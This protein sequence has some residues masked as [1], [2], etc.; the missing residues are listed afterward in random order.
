MRMNKLSKSVLSVVLSGAMIMGMGV[1]AS[2]SEEQSAD[3]V[4]LGFQMYNLRVGGDWGNMQSQE[5][6]NDAL[7]QLAE[8][9][10]EGVEWFNT[11]LNDEFVDLEE[12]RATM[13]ELGLESI[14]MHYHYNSEDLE[15]SAQEVVERCQTLGCENL[16]FAYSVPSTFGIEPDED[17][18]YT[19]EQVDQWVSEIDRVIDALE[20]A[21]EGRDIR[22]LY[23]N[24]ATEMLTG[25]EGEH[26]LDMID[27]EGLEVDVYWTSKGLDG[28]VETA[29]DYVRE[30]AD[31]IYFL[32]MKDG[33]DGSLATGEMCGWG[34]GT[35][36]LQEIVDV[37]KEC[38][39]LEWVVVEN[40]NPNNFGLTGLEDAAESAEYAKANIDFSYAE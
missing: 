27:T 26:A 35:Y 13:D 15:G 28:S 6:L 3:H 21:A 30:N 24:H 33:L 5:D 39:N 14:G 9:G 16:I 10:Y 31:D 1:M 12:T 2:A 23:H 22:V 25:T 18:N 36:N 29:L 34:K 32:H 4:K 19:A 20:T 7:T 11:A 8:D 40:D 38:P 17:G 37:A